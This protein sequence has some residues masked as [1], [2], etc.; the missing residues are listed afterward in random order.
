VE[1]GGEAHKTR[2]RERWKKE[3]TITTT[4]TGITYCCSGTRRSTTRGSRY[5]Q[6]LISLKLHPKT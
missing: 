6:S 1:V 2:K 4:T 5:G 3:I